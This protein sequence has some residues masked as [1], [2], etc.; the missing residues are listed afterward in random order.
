MSGGHQRCVR[1]AWSLKKSFDP[2]VRYGK[3]A[4][5]RALS[6]CIWNCIYTVESKA[7][8]LVNWPLL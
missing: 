6:A 4:H 7:L 8:H 5:S 1:K 3:V 2:K